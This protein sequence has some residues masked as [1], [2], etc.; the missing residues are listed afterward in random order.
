MGQ[1]M[2][3]LFNGLENPALKHTK[4]FFRAQL[5]FASYALGAYPRFRRN[6]CW[7]SMDK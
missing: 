2:R 4:T 6:N 7:P 1:N 3:K 5:V